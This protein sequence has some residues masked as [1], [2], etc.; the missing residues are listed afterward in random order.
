MV[1]VWKREREDY[2]RPTRSIRYDLVRNTVSIL[3]IRRE[4]ILLELR[5]TKHSYYCSPNNYYVGN[6]NGENHGR[7]EYDTWPEFKKEWLSEREDESRL[8]D[9]YNHV[10][11]F[12]ILEKR[13]SETDKPIGRYS[14]WLF[15]ILQR[16]GI[17]RPVRV[18]E[19]T[20]EDMAEIEQFLKD[21]W[22]YLKNQWIEFS[23]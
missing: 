21:R 8:D 3:L 13:D 11:R 10:F 5:E 18:K 6:F 1:D 20:K 22:Q 15:F 23:E 19:I 2:R 4:L 17:Y 12:D 9:D 14:L 7:C 16:K